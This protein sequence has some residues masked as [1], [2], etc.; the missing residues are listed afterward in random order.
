MRSVN[1]TIANLS[2]AD[3]AV[4][5][6]VKGDDGLAYTLSTSND[7][8]EKQG[9]IVGQAISVVVGDDGAAIGLG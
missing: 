7:T 1:G 9:L 3:D 4:I 6:D 5:V 8:V 2:L